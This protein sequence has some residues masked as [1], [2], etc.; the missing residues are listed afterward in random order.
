MLTGE[1]LDVCRAGYGGEALDLGTAYRYDLI[2]MSMNLPDISARDLVS[3]LRAG[4]IQSPVLTFTGR[5]GPA[6]EITGPMLSAND[7]AACW[8]GKDDLIRHVRAMLR[9]TK[10]PLPRILRYGALRVDL[11][12]REAHMN[13]RPIS[14]SANE[15][16]MLEQIYRQQYDSAPDRKL[17]HYHMGASDKGIINLFQRKLTKLLS[18][19][20]IG[21]LH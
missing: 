7:N 8:S 15:Y 12:A 21:T 10:S 13:G 19:A 1:G 17:S 4:N 3:K 14:F 18:E 11:V 2:L 16:S 20:D 5:S 6:H 9:R